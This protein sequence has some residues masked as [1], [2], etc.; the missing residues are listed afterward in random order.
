[1]CAVY[2]WL[3]SEL[4]NTNIIGNMPRGDHCAVWG[5]NSDRRYPEKQ[6]ILYHVGIL[7]FY[8]P[9]SIS[10]FSE[11]SISTFST[12]IRQLAKM[13]P[14]HQSKRSDNKRYAVEVRWGIFFENLTYYFIPEGGR[15]YAH[16]NSYNSAMTVIAQDDMSQL[17]LG[18]PMIKQTICRI[19]VNDL[20]I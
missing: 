14:F 15:K 17:E 5:C 1:M 19:S 6:S 2:F 7:R 16:T 20:F 10:H 12:F 8:Y 3:I 4:V 9:Q 11:L 13:R 18:P